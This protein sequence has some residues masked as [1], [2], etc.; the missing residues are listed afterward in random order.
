MLQLL[1]DNPWLALSIPIAVTIVACV[2]ICIVPEHLRQSRQAE[3][4]A[5]LKHDMLNRG[6]SAADIKTVLEAS[7]DGEV[8][9]MALHQPV[10]VGLGKFQVEVGS[11]HRSANATAGSPAGHG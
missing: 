7:T 1:I 5:M 2:A 8:T 10:R 3:I 9:R 6:M 11:G 4:D